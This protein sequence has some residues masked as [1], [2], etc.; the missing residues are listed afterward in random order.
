MR[1]MLL[2]IFFLLGGVAVFVL[3]SP[4]FAVFPTN[5]NQTYLIVLTVVL[6]GLSVLLRRSHSLSAH[7]PPVYS[8]FVASAALLFLSTGILNIRSGSTDPLQELALDKLSQFLHIVPAIIALSL[9]ARGTPRSLYVAK[10]KLRAGLLFGAISF[11]GFAILALL[12]QVGTGGLPPL[13]ARALAMAL[14]FAF[15]NATMEELWFRAI[16]LK[17]YQA[18]I[19]RTAAIIVTSIIFGYSHVFA[20]YD[21]PGGSVVFGLVVFALGLVGAYSMT[22][23]DSLIGPILFHAGYDL[24][25]IAPVLASM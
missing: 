8:L 22:K 24:I 5:R 3:G 16:F 12:L 7:A 4:Y 2:S 6:L 11:V 21:F 14:L 17:P 19:G 18:V 13:T 15:L 25:I 20:S 23:T 1:I 9:V 10:G